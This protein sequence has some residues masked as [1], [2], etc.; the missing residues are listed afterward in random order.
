MPLP[1]LESLHLH[2]YSKK[3][4]ESQSLLD[5]PLSLDIEN[6]ISYWLVKNSWGSDWGEE[7]YVKIGRSNSTNDPGICGIAMKPSLPIV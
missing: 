1:L 2:I 6:G 4:L 3:L 5:I 7:G